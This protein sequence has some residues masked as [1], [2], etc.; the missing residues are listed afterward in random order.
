MKPVVVTVGA[1]VGLEKVTER[2][3]MMSAAVKGR[4]GFAMVHLLGCRGVVERWAKLVQVS[5]Q[6]SAE[7]DEQECSVEGICDCGG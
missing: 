2:W 6:Q 3:V 5:C 4:K 7:F 1:C